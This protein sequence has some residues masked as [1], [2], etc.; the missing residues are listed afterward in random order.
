MVTVLADTFPTVEHGAA[1][2]GNHARD[3]RDGGQRGGSE[4]C[5]CTTW[6]NRSHKRIR[7]YLMI[8]WEGT[9]CIAA[10]DLQCHLDACRRFNAF[11]FSLATHAKRTWVDPDLIMNVRQNGRYSF[12][13]R[14][15]ICRRTHLAEKL[16]DLHTEKV[17][18]RMASTARWP[19]EIQATHRCVFVCESGSGSVCVRRVLVW[20]KKNQTTDRSNIR[21]KTSSLCCRRPRTSTCWTLPA[22]QRGDLIQ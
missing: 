7:V 2:Q 4:K 9:S 17:A 12:A 8:T 13:T 20:S 22:S 6:G 14:S 15:H 5:P 16:L 3:L 19:F 1:E 18:F 11:N 21:N 10:Q